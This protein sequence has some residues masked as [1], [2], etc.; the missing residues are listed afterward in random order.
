MS[1]F[2]CFVKNFVTFG[3]LNYL[4]RFFIKKIKEYRRRNKKEIDADT[5]EKR[6]N[7]MIQA[8]ENQGKLI[9]QIEPLAVKNH[10][11]EL[12]KANKGLIIHFALYGRGKVLKHIANEMNFVTI[13]E[14]KEHINSICANIDNEVIDVTT[15]V[16]YLIKKDDKSSYSSIFMHQAPKTKVIGFINPIFKSD[17]TSY[18]LIK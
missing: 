14:E 18:L 1:F 10:N 15:P 7:E 8:R 6:R 11:H 16:R 13:D 9:S 4:T 3:V 5:L 12:N 2:N 17:K